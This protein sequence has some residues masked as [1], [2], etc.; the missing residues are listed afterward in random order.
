MKILGITGG[1]GSGKSAVL[2]DL[3]N[4]Y[5]AYILKADELANSLKK[6]GE[7]GY[8]SIVELL[9]KDILGDD[10]EI[11]NKKMAQRIFSDPE[12]LAKVNDILHPIVKEHILRTIEQKRAEGTTKLFVLEAALLLEEGYDQIV[13]EMWYIY[14][15]TATRAERLR[16]SRGYSD[17][18]IQSI[19][20][21]Q[22]SEED[23]RKGCDVVIDNSGTMEDT[24]KQ[25][26]RA[27]T[28]LDIDYSPSKIH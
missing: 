6:K 4:R 24:R 25:I 21:K 22:L 13:D 5:H 7:D 15:D 14:A 23:F 28:G 27:I 9:G 18:K 2:D 10:D 19:M 16:Q 12:A 20:A 1:V 26:D 17:E 11:D 3:Q 8:R